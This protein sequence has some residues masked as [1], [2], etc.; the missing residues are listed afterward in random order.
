MTLADY[1]VPSK[2]DVGR[3]F[4][5]LVDYYVHTQRQCV[6]P[7]LRMAKR[8]AQAMIDMDSPQLMSTSIV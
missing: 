6:Q 1:C 2:G 5:M 3:K 8:C 4:L 7:R